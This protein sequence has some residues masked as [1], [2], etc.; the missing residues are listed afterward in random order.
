MPAKA[1]TLEE[2]HRLPDDGNEYEVIRGE[3]FVTPLPSVDHCRGVARELED[4][5]V[6][7]KVGVKRPCRAAQRPRQWRP[8]AARSR[9]RTTIRSTD[10]AGTLTRRVRVRFPMIMS[11]LVSG[12]WVHPESASAVSFL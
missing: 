8:R 11:V 1:W 4:H 9:R 2:L 10:A 5:R 6:V 7:D 12:E 3:L